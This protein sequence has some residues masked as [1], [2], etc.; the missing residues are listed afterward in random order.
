MRDGG[1]GGS[2]MSDGRVLLLQSDR[3]SVRVRVL[4]STGV[5]DRWRPLSRKRHGG[6]V[7][8]VPTVR[9]GTSGSLLGDLADRE[10]GA[11]GA[12]GGALTG[13]VT[14]EEEVGAA[15]G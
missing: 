12:T 3:E 13:G 6:V 1:A 9:E 14:F 11:G 8:D 5:W 15:M 10:G 7:A 2:G 4:R